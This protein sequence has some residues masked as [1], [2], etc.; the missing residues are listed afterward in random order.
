MI[1]KSIMTMIMTTS[2]RMTRIKRNDAARTSQLMT[3][4]I[5]AS[6]K[7]IMS[8]TTARM[9][10]TVP[11]DKHQS[12]QQISDNAGMQRTCDL[13]LQVAASKHRDVV[14]ATAHFTCQPLGGA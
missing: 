3:G 6:V 1:T 4:I 2:M 9:L 12:K 14:C 8:C 11:E 5:G 10:G 7:E 13:W